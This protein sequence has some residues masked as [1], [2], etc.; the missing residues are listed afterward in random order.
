MFHFSTRVKTSPRE[1]PSCQVWGCDSINNVSATKQAGGAEWIPRTQVKNKWEET[2]SWLPQ[3][4]GTVLAQRVYPF[5]KTLLRPCLLIPLLDLG[6]ANQGKKRQVTTIAQNSAYLH[7]SVQQ[8]V[9]LCLS[10]PPRTEASQSESR[11]C[12]PAGK[13]NMD[14]WGSPSTC[15][16]SNQPGFGT[17][18]FLTQVQQKTSSKQPGKY[19]TV[20]FFSIL[21]HMHLVQDIF[22]NN[23]VQYQL[24]LNTVHT[25]S[26]TCK[27]KIARKIF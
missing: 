12:H 17:S 13:T 21:Q 14:G 5:S 18:P 19:S 20:Q 6:F 16:Q 1:S 8:N 7:V 15:T 9:A 26:H 10:S 2:K 22:A 23:F 24:L 3:G 25:L 4:Q 11:K 27:A